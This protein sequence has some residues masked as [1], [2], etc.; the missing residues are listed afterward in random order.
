MVCD[1]P[2]YLFC[3]STSNQS[4]KL[5]SLEKMQSPIQGRPFF[6]V[7]KTALDHARNLRTADQYFV[8]K[9]ELLV[10]GKQLLVPVMNFQ[11]VV[12]LM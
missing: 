9:K 8:E 12:Q 7:K 10:S 6:D 2:D 3:Y 11:I 5:Q 4:E 1:D